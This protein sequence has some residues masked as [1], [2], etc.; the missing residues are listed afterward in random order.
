MWSALRKQVA[1]RDLAASLEVRRPC[2]ERHDVGLA[3]LELGRVLDRDDPVVGGDEGRQHV[4]SGRLAR[5]GAAGDEDVEP[6]PD[7]RPQELEHL[8]RCRPEAD[9]VVDR[10][11]FGGELPDGDDRPDERQRRDDGIDARAVGKPGVDARARFIDAPTE[12]RD[13]PLDDPA[14]VLVVEERDVDALDLASRSM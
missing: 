5:A 10:E 3:E 8:G 9:Q 2:L 14:D 4:E 6:G 13:D 1:D 7:A 12:R 11:R